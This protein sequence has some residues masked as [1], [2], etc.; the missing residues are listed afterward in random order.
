MNV[1]GDRLETHACIVGRDRRESARHT[2]HYAHLTGKR[3]DRNLNPFLLVKPSIALLFVNLIQFEFRFRILIREEPEAWN[4]GRPA[5]V[6]CFDGKDL[7][8]KRVARHGALDE[9]RAADLVKLR[10]DDRIYCLLSG[11]RCDLAIGRV[12]AIERYDLAAPDPKDWWEAV[13]CV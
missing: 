12:E 10:E 9:N 1:L 7:D 13:K 4:H 6:G 8:L 3:P 5:P 11:G 2:A